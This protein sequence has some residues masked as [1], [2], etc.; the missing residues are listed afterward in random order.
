MVCHPE[1][2]CA[3]SRAA[4]YTSLLPP[5]AVL[6]RFAASGPAAIARP[7]HLLAHNPHSSL[8]DV[9]TGAHALHLM[10]GMAALFYMLVRASLAMRDTRLELSRQSS[11]VR[12]STLYWHF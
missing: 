10:G 12:V 8:F 2:F 1:L 7:R 3:E 4:R 6:K 5:K 11:L 9:V